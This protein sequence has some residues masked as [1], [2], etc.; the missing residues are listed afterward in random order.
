MSKR[1]RDLSSPVTEW[2]KWL[3]GLL[4][5]PF[6][7]LSE[8]QKFWTGFIVLCLLTTLL[9]SNPW[10]RAVAEPTYQ[11]GD[12]ARESIIAPADISFADPQEA[13]RLQQEA[14][15]AVKPIFRYESNK[16]ERAVQGFLSSWEVLQRHGGEGNTNRPPT[17]TDAKGEIHWTG[18]GGADVGKTLASRNFSRNEIDAVVSAL[19]ES[20]DGY[21]YDDSEKQYFSNEVFVFDRS[22][23]NQRST[24]TMPESNWIAL[25]AARDKLRTRLTAIKSLSLKEQDAFYTAASI[26]VEPSV[27]YD[28]VATEQARATAAETIRPQNIALKRGQ[29]IVDEGGIITPD[30]LAKIYAI[31]QYT[32]ASRQASRT[33]G[34]LL[35][36]A[37]LFWVAWKFVQHRGMLPRLALSA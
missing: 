36:I 27:S 2:R 32:A 29:K 10:W 14:R 8:D 37:A 5:K 9:I 26:L 31:Q 23:P 1:I 24:V 4:G 13:Q 6:S 28:S 7:R 33:V 34:V 25:S 12:V 17:N 35:F 22:K 21:I 20:A 18:A 16:P 30:V 3:L 11:E 15:T 19:R